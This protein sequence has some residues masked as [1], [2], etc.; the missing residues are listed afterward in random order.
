[1]FLIL[2]PQIIIKFL[3]KTYLKEPYLYLKGRQRHVRH[4]LRNLNPIIYQ[5]FNTII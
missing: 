3:K 2:K 5:L 1:M 4:L